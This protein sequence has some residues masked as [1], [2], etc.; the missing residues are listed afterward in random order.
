MHK[1]PRKVK[2]ALREHALK[3]IFWLDY[4]T[5][6]SLW[7]GRW[8]RNLG[9]SR[10]SVKLKKELDSGKTNPHGRCRQS[11]R[12]WVRRIEATKPDDLDA[13]SIGCGV[14]E[15]VA[16]L[17]VHLDVYH[18][19]DLVLVL[20]R[21]QLQRSTRHASSASIPDAAKHED[22]YAFGPPTPRQDR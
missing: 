19:I 12:S 17:K 4:D 22:V 11:R 9:P 6:A 21:L 1:E 5:L 10:R 18:V 16:G 8:R 15:E 14:A 3:T 13:A 7:N 20:D 2:I